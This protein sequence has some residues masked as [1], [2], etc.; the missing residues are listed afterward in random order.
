ML[1]EDF[2]RP[3]RSRFDSGPEGAGAV[4]VPWVREDVKDRGLTP[5]AEGGGR[6]FLGPATRVRWKS[7]GPPVPSKPHGR[8]VD[9]DS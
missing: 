7:V 2:S 9:A 3:R 1:T 8:C 5:D 6:L 4:V